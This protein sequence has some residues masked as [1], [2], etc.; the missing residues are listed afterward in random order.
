LE[1]SKNI[2]IKLLDFFIYSNLLISVACFLFTL[3]TALAFHT[4]ETAAAFFGI[5]NFIATFSLY[6][7]QRIYQSTKPYT[8]HR[9]A[10]YQRNKKYLFTL[11]LVFI[12]LYYSVFI[13]NYIVFKN[14]LLLYLPAGALSVVYFLPPFALRRMPV[15]KIFLIGG[16]WAYTSVFIPLL[17]NE[18]VFSFS[19]I[20]VS[21][22]SY[23][24]AQLFFI[25]AICVPFDIRDFENDR[26]NSI[27][28]LPVQFGLGKSKTI[29]I[30]VLLAYIFLAQNTTQF[31]VFGITGL[32]GILLIYFSYEH[33][34]RYYFSVLVDGL[35]I[36][37]FVLY[38]LLTRN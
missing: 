20:G 5:T 15:S 33:K 7:L 37:Q 21:E 4:S 26:Q 23:I 17:Y 28:T 38:N 8:D 18:S 14:G 13:N 25:A 9:L 1:Q 6:N 27:K 34:H 2:G 30:V 19:N 22:L 10:W 11:I 29:G 36:L 3:Q 32:L 24:I 31:A 12:S 16:V 35:I